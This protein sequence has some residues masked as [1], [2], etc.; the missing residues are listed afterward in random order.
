MSEPVY[1]RTVT[2]K[3]S[4]GF[5][6]RP[7]GVFAEA[8]QQFQSKIEL[9]KDDLRIDGKSALSIMTLCA[10]QGTELSVEGSGPDA[11]RAVNAL[12]SFVESGFENSVGIEDLI[13]N[14]DNFPT[15]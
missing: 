8:A 1:S 12:A 7:A 4:R 9:I 14:D 6:L 15:S 2:I 11:E 5:H 3:N 10:E 13:S